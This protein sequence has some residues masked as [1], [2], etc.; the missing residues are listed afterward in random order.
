[1]GHAEEHDQGEET[2]GKAETK[3]ETDGQRSLLMAR[4]RRK[5]VIVEA[6]RYHRMF[7][8]WPHWAK[9]ELKHEMADGFIVARTDPRMRK[10]LAYE[11][12]DD[13]LIQTSE[14]MVLAKPGDYIVRDAT[15]EIYPCEPKLF[16]KT[17]E[18][19]E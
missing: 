19:V 3:A 8:D 12:D 5:A 9:A 4:Y 18:R 6:F 11:D 17:H 10:I 14:G 1:M 13:L 7:A 16:E 2:E 15:G